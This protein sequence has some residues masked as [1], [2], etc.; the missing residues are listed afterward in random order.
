MDDEYSFDPGSF[1]GLRPVP[2]DRLDF[3]RTRKVKDHLSTFFQSM[4][5]STSDSLVSDCLAL[6]EPYRV[7]HPRSALAPVSTAAGIF[8]LRTLG[9]AVDLKTSC[10]RL[11]QSRRL[12]GRVLKDLEIS[13]PR[14]PKSLVARAQDALA[15]LVPK[16][17]VEISDH[18]QISDSIA[19]LVGEKILSPASLHCGVL[20]VVIFWTREKNKKISVRDYAA[21]VQLPLSTTY[22]A[23]KAVE[24]FFKHALA[25]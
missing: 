15:A 23:L 21:A 14:P 12:V 17:P 13:S 25:P 6:I 19:L 18:Q 22:Q 1:F 10:D 8:V 4:N 9:V 3:E 5:V 7:R 16:L 2:L 20:A 24:K 11:A